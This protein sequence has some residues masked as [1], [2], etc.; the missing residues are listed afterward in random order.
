MVKS[1]TA[2]AAAVDG[3]C[4]TDV[5]PR[6]RKFSRGSNSMATTSRQRSSPRQRPPTSVECLGQTDDVK[7][8][9]NCRCELRG[10]DIRSAGISGAM[11]RRNAT[12][13][14]GHPRQRVGRQRAAAGPVLQTAIR[15]DSSP[16][17]DQRPLRRPQRNG[18][19]RARHR[20]PSSIAL[21]AH[22]AV[23]TAPY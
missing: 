19:R 12:V 9:S 5:T 2:G 8:K 15:D 22:S 1:M 4:S 11:Q 16:R 7:T 13:S 21:R 3:W 23:H 6:E 10:P 20:R 18:S 14:L 17:C